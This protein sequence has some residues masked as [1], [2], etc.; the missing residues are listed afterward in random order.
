MVVVGSMNTVRM[1]LITVVLSLERAVAWGERLAVA[2][3]IIAATAGIGMSVLTLISI[4]IT[5]ERTATSHERN[6]LD[7]VCS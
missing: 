7:L 6:E 4:Q 5:I 1:W 2:I 3:G